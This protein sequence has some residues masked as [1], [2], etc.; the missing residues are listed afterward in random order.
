MGTPGDGYVYSVNGP[1][2]ETWAERMNGG[3]SIEGPEV[4]PVLWSCGLIPALS[5]RRGV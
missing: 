5:A 3:G 1:R 4:L 2:F